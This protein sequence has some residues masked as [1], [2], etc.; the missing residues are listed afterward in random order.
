LLRDK[1]LIDDPELIKRAKAL[2]CYKPKKQGKEHDREVLIASLSDL[3]QDDASL[4]RWSPLAKNG[5]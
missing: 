1:A 2:K 5:F 4:H 3:N